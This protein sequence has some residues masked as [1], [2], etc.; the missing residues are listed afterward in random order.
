MMTIRRFYRISEA[1][2]P[3]PERG[4]LVT[5]GLITYELQPEQFAKIGQLVRRVCGI[6][7]RPGKEELVRSRLIKRLSTLELEDFDAYLAYVEGDTSGRELITMID[8][9]TTNKTNFFREAQHFTF[10]VQHVLPALQAAGQPMRFWSA[11]CSSG[12]EPYSIAMTLREEIQNIDRRDVRIL[13]TDISTQVL[14]IARHAVYD[15]ENL[16][17]VPAHLLRKYFTKVQHG[18]SCVY[19]VH[20]KVRAMV[21]LARLNLMQKWP[22][23]GSFDTIFCRNVMIYFDKVTQEWLVK[24]FWSL[25]RPG[26]YLFLGHSESLAA[27][28]GMFRYV[29]PAVY[30]K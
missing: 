29:Q 22:M 28:S 12:E 17:E 8:V 13:G 19:Q 4:N 26:G 14:A 10:L 11:G 25:L 3:L 20:D 6:N 24:R 21:R 27:G 2:V 16:D 5:I 15:Q 9:L 30:I 1:D 23:Q 18:R 7:L